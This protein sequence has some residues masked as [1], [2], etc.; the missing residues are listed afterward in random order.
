MAEPGSGEQEDVLSLEVMTGVGIA[1]IL[2]VACLAGWFLFKANAFFWAKAV[3]TLLAVA[4]FT[5]IGWHWFV[6]DDSQAEVTWIVGITMACMF[7]FFHCYHAC[8]VNKPAIEGRDPRPGFIRLVSAPAGSAA[9][10]PLVG[11]VVMAPLFVPVP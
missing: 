4:T 2:I 8:C 9:E 11:K 1:T 5:L 6:S 3:S 7:G 10:T